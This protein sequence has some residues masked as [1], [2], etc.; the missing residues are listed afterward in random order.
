MKILFLINFVI[1]QK[2]NEI[3]KEI[4]GNRK[5]GTFPPVDM[6]EVPNYSMHNLVMPLFI[7]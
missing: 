2:L 3:F 5:L 7:P 6:L 4:D 1:S